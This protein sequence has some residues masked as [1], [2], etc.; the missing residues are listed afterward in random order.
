MGIVRVSWAQTAEF[1][2]SFSAANPVLQKE[3]RKR[4]IWLKRGLGSKASER[5]MFLLP[6]PAK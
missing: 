6:V 1:A 2:K 5:E 3:T 4:G